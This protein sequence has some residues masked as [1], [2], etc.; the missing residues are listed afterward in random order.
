MVKRDEIH[1]GEQQ[2]ADNFFAGLRGGL[3]AG[4]F[5]GAD[6]RRFCGGAGHK[7][8]SPQHA[9]RH[10]KA[11]IQSPGF[12]E[13]VHIRIFQPHTRKAAS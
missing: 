6:N 13:A 1:R 3:C 11:A 12:I 9:K 4:E 8:V 7:R 5:A 2:G 10:R